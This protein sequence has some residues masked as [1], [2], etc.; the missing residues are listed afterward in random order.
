MKRIFLVLLLACA[1]CFTARAFAAWQAY[2]L[3]DGTICI[4]DQLLEG[5]PITTLTLGRGETRYIEV[6]GAVDYS[7]YASA[8]YVAHVDQDGMLKTEDVGKGKLKVYYTKTDA[9]TFSVNVKRAPTSISLDRKSVSLEPGQQKAL[10]YTLSKNSAGFVSFYSGNEDVVSVDSHGLLTAHRPGTAQ[11]FAETYNGHSARCDVT[12]VMPAPATIRVQQSFTG[13]AFE[14]FSLNA[15]LD[16]GYMETLSYASSDESVLRV[17]DAGCVSCLKAGTARITLN[18]S[19]GASAQVNVN[20]LSQ[21]AAIAPRQSALCLYEGG[22]AAIE[23]VTT[24]GSGRFEAESLDPDVAVVQPDGTVRALK[25]GRGR[26]LLTAPGGA[27]CVLPVN[28]YET[29]G[30]LKQLPQVDPVAIGESERIQI[31]DE[32]GVQMPLRFA[33]SDEGVLRVSPDGVVSALSRGSALISVSSGGVLLQQTVQAVPPASGIAFEQS[34]IDMGEGDTLRVRARHLGGGGHISY[35][36]N[37]PQVASVTEDG[38]VRALKSGIATITA[39]LAHGGSA[40]MDVYVRQSAQS[41]YPEKTRVVIGEG[42]STFVPCS[43]DVGRFSLLKW[44]SENESLF[45]VDENGTIRSVSGTGEADAVVTAASGVRARVR[46]VVVDA[47]KDMRLDAL[48]LTQPGLFTDYVALP[49]GQTHALNAAFDG[50][51]AVHCVYLSRDPQIATVDENGLITAL[52]A[53][54]ARV[55]VTAYNGLTREVLVEVTAA[56]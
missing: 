26:L 43:F 22:T 35:S 39:R 48:R 2:E 36:S 50:L 9:V 13:Y 31:Y 4:S 12:V 6:R 47:P 16:G 3:A 38:V 49:A 32:I 5:D 25:S 24:G 40:Q 42:D 30:W 56:Q 1:V 33:S 53:G 8:Y 14:D 10:D 11:V 55:S 23:A 18:A 17:D 29:P 45:T 46:V 20:V 34:A 37:Q 51:D 44:Q 7:Y 52:A 28:V 19:G 27:Q 15:A 21:A 54:S 41:I